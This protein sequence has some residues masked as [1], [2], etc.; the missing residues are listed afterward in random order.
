MQETRYIQ[1]SRSDFV[2]CVDLVWHFYLRRH[3]K[4]N[5]AFKWSLAWRS[6]WSWLVFTVTSLFLGPG[7]RSRQRRPSK[8][9]HP[10]VK[11]GTPAQAGRACKG[12]RVSRQEGWKMQHE[13]PMQLVR[14]P[15][16]LPLWPFHALHEVLVPT[17]SA[18]IVIFAW[19]TSPSQFTSRV[20]PVSPAS[21][22]C[23]ILNFP[24]P[25]DPY[26]GHGAKDIADHRGVLEEMKENTM[27]MRCQ[28][29]MEQGAKGLREQK[30]RWWRHSYKSGVHIIGSPWRNNFCSS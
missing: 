11:D 22:C 4:S 1:T 2:R 25:F 15:L 30:W 18:A 19:C 23:D 6:M 21:I 28:G 24:C 17:P 12:Y 26:T 16:T 14:D 3:W 27:P 5:S 13:A 20:S 10:R 8:R 7:L 9:T 29:Q